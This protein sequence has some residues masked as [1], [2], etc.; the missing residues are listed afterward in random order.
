LGYVEGIRVPCGWVTSVANVVL[1]KYSRTQPEFDA[2]AV[3]TYLPGH[4]TRKRNRF[5][6][7][8]W[9]NWE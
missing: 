8:S 1:P 5:S 7:S 2:A 3:H 6:P 9:A 4:S